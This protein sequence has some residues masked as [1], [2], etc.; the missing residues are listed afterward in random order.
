MFAL[1]VLSSFP[2]IATLSV[3]N[4][5]NFASLPNSKVI[6]PS[7]SIVPLTG[8]MKVPA[9]MSCFYSAE[10]AIEAKINGIYSI[11]RGINIINSSYF[12]KIN[13]LEGNWF[14][15][16]YEIV[17]GY[18]LAKK[19]NL[20]PNDKISVE[21]VLTGN[22][23]PFLVSGIFYSNYSIFNEEGFVSIE[24]ARNLSN[25]PEGYFSYVRVP[26]NCNS[27]KNL[28]SI[29]V[30]LSQ[31]FSRILSGFQSASSNYSVYLGSQTLTNE[32][33]VIS[34][35]I[36]IS[37]LSS[38]WFITRM[39]IYSFEK[40]LKILYEQGVSEKGIK[41]AIILLVLLLFIPLTFLSS[42]L[43]YTIILR[44]AF[45]EALHYK[46]LLPNFINVSLLP[47][48]AIIISLISSLFY[49]LSK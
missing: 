38:V 48:E 40:D 12:Y 8:Y 14:S 5:V 17:I 49:K 44:F 29:S 22:V 41:I 4:D 15:N 28:N 39:Y 31:V 7:N 33:S 36:I 10:I 9:N 6:V 37:I 35:I 18:D 21:D 20:K 25:I 2:Y 1:L 26:E 11:I 16:V 23:Q 45:T 42:Y 27:V 24:A 3:V 13:I 46:A 19:L 47:I 43:S 32:I 34:L 30:G